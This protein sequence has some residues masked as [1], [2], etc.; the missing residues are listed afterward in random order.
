MPLRITGP[1]GYEVEA[2]SF[3]D[4]DSTTGDTAMPRTDKQL[5]SEP[6]DKSDERRRAREKGKIKTTATTPDGS[7]FI[8]PSGHR[9]DGKCCPDCPLGTHELNGDWRDPGTTS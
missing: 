7:E 6:P 3:T 8:T 5:D 9:D 1:G 4:P 2:T